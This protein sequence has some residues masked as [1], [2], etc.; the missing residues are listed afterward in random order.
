MGKN[1]ND[2]VTMSA[3]TDITSAIY[4]FL[5]FT[6]DIAEQHSDGTVPMLDVRV[7]Q[8]EEGSVVHNFY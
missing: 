3:W 2:Y 8:W 1:S 4:P 7:W 6:I 5:K